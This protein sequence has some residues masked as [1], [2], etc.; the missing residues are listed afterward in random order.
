MTD[1]PWSPGAASGVGSLPGTDITEAVKTVLG[2]LPDLPYLPE[3]PARGPG[4]DM[5]GRTA[6]LLVA[7]P[8]DVYA[9]RW[10]TT[11]RPGRDARRTHDLM[12]RDLDVLTEL[13]AGLAGPLKVQAAGPWT[14]AAEID[15]PAGG[16]LLRD[17][18]AVRDLVASLR[19]GLRGHL[20]EVAKRVPGAS[21]VLQLD[22]PSLPA[23]LAGRVPTESGLGTLR[24]VEASDAE[25]ALRSIVEAVGVPVVVHCC[26]AGV[27]VGLAHSAGAAGVS[28]DIGLLSG[29]AELDSLGGLIDA[30]GALFAGAAPAVDPD[31]GGRPSSAWVAD[32][33]RALWSQLGF[34]RDRIA[35]QV[36]VTPT[37]G[38]AGATPDYA[39]AV[40]KVC[41][42]AGRRLTEET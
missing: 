35:G 1:L 16:R 9:G 13:A 4:A 31:E 5:I 17:E 34:P 41:A 7:L 36:V 21:L 6:G 27:P 11:V 10:R 39:R 30:G 24:P 8:V 28:L 37:C 38:L 20:T 19:E 26:A 32:R 42:E 15:L 25:S 12:E 18:G 22:E 2:E 29:T 3:L 40:L 23:V 33:V 14:L